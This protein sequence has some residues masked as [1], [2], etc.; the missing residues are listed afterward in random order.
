MSSLLSP[1]RLLSAVPGAP[2]LLS[3]QALLLLR[4]LCVRQAGVR[5]HELGCQGLQRG[6]SEQDL[7]RACAL[8]KCPHLAHHRDRAA[9]S[10]AQVEKEASFFKPKTK[11]TANPCS[12][13]EMN[14][15]R[16]ACGT[17]QPAQPHRRA[18][19]RANQGALRAQS[20]RPGHS[21][22]RG[23]SCRPPPRRALELRIARA[24]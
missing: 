4:I 13:I 12:S 15:G 8:P 5:H 10:G 14:N 24:A 17:S 7:E 3:P 23:T 21:G 16:A 2:P 22:P 1:P 20:V 19:W 9:A 18:F 11:F 6:F